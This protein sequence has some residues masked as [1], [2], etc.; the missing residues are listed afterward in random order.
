MAGT[1]D[2]LP[3]GTLKFSITYPLTNSQTVTDA[4]Q[5]VWN[6]F[7]IALALQKDSACMPLT[8]VRV[9]IYAHTPAENTVLTAEVQMQ[10]ILDLAD[11]T[12]DE[13]DFIN[14]VKY[15]VETPEPHTQQ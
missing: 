10:A 12:A 5:I 13:E 14:H 15:T 8:R 1:A 9:A 3:N 2:V 4:A 6:A 11:G 7:D